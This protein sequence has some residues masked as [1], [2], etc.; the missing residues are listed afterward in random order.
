MPPNTWKRHLS[1]GQTGDDLHYSLAL[2]YR[3]LGDAARAEAHLTQRAKGQL[4]V[5][6]PLMDEVRRMLQSSNT[7]ESRGVQ[8]LEANDYRTA[9]MY[10]RKG[11]EL[12]PDD[13]SLH[14]RLGTAM[15]LGGDVEGGRGQFETALRLAPDLAR[16]HYN[17][18]GAVCIGRPASRATER[19][20]AAVRHDSAYVEARLLL[21]D[22][23][24][25]TGH[26]KEA[27][28][29]YEEVIEL[30]P[31]VAQAQLGHALALTDLGEYGKALARLV[32]ATTAFPNDATLMQALA[33]L[34]AAAPDASVRD[35][36]Q[37]VALM[38]RALSGQSAPG[39]EVS[40]AMAMAYAETGEFR[41]AVSWQRMAMV[42]AERAGRDPGI[43]REMGANLRLFERGKPSRTPSADYAMP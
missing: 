11:L 3:G 34:R 13:A 15:V 17:S 5:P 7:F 41:Q 30:D 26:S 10:F 18:R 2:A 22:L 32:G 21:G 29:Q 35:G 43:V 14:H 40:E 33:R 25:H 6:D 27:L 20:S 37:A 31:R 12:A 42:A 28:Q 16:A 1:R 24:R 23:S 39:P 19:L 4:A 38:Q 9:S 36:T 8:A